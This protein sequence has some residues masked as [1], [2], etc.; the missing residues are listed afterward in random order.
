M[1]ELSA[2]MQQLAKYN[3]LKAQGPLPRYGASAGMQAKADT[4]L[5]HDVNVA[6]NFYFPF[7]FQ[8][9]LA[10]P[11]RWQR[12]GAAAAAGL[13]RLLLP[14]PSLASGRGATTTPP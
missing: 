13:P 11:C 10:C 2:T 7:N 14:P 4:F 5:P 8:L 6:L 3:A 1:L 9:F 12:R